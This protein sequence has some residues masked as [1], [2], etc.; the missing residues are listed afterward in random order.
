MQMQ[1]SFEVVDNSPVFKLRS[2]LHA[3]LH[4]TT[5]LTDNTT[6]LLPENR[7]IV[8]VP[9][10]TS[11]PNTK[12]Y[13][14]H[15]ETPEEAHYGRYVSKRVGGLVL[16]SMDERGAYTCPN[17]MSG[18]EVQIEVQL[19]SGFVLALQNRLRATSETN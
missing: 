10:E 1:R 2:S 17:S 18:A 3:L 11:L 5:D 6:L 19:L 16:D 8:T 12:I 14:C 9:T 15:F 7:V 4:L 13:L